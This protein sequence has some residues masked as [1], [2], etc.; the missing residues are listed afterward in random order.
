MD[1]KYWVPALERAHAVLQCIAEQPSKLRLMDLTK[2]T[3]I[4]KSSMFSILHTMEALEWVKREKGDTYTLGSVFAFLGNAYFSGINLVELFAEKA[5]ETVE[6]V[7]ETVQL[8]RL[9]KGD[10]VYLA[11]KEAVSPVRLLSEPGMRI[12]AYA[13]AMGKMLLSPMDR[14]EIRALF[15]GQTLQPFT[16]NT[17]RSIDELFK[18]LEEVSS[19]GYATDIEEVVPG[20][21]CAAAPIYNRNGDMIAAV[22]FSMPSHHWSEKRE[23]AVSEIRRLAKLLS[24]AV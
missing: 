5:A 16:S 23:S 18:Q 4:N 21:C 9:E 12:P 7:G 15:P 3:G 17:I 10:I 19:Q 22:S 2:A 13:T 24:D 14:Q 8:A 11:K 6:R 20:F 1:K